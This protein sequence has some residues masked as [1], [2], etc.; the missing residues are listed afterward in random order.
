MWLEQGKLILDGL[1]WCL[2]V[3][4]STDDFTSS[5]KLVVRKI[6]FNMKG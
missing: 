1:L 4:Y 5:L 6:T 2:Y 3:F